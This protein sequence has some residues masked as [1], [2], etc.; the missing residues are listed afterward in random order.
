M[1][2]QP[3]TAA[4]AKDLLVMITPLLPYV[5][6]A[7]IAAATAIPISVD[8]DVSAAAGRTIHHVHGVSQ[9]VHI[10]RST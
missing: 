6:T 5:F 4:G 8:C 10:S 2:S 7:A 3:V 9:P 1:E